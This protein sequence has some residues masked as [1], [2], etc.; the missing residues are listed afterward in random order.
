MKEFFKP[1]RTD[2]IIYRS[3]VISVFLI[4][5][6]LIY[7][8]VRF[9]SLPPFIPI[10]NQLPWGNE[11]I[12]P[13]FT[14]F[15]PI[16]ATVLIFMINLALSSFVYEKTPLMS[17]IFSITTLLTILLILIFSVVIISLVV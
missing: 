1:V 10:F 13:R 9:L 3:T 11:R 2:R 8:L 15:I 16:L 12:G 14:I 17:R 6:T 5:L 4:S 7:A